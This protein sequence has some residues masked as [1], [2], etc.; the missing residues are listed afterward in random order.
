MQGRI[1]I[2]V[3]SFILLCSSAG[4]AQDDA[5]TYSAA[6]ESAKRGDFNTAFM[7]F[8][9][10]LTDNSGSGYYTKALFAAGEYYFS[11]NDYYDATKAFIDFINDS[12]DYNGNLFALVYLLKIAQ[13]QK[14]DS[15]AENL[16]NKIV[17][18]RELVLVFSDYKEYK[19]VSP[20]GKKYIL[21]YYIDKAQCYI[22]KELFA[23]IPY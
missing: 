17:N 9:N 12:A 23:D 4:Y 16:K 3:L 15:G 18:L 8:H 19:F 6:L 21:R 10:I 22:G 20:M 2:A 5:R 7:L 14:N 1:F 13:A 11:Q